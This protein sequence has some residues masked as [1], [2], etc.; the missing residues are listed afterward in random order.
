MSDTSVVIMV[1][2]ASDRERLDL[3]RSELVGALSDQALAGCSVVVAANKQDVHSALGAEEVADALGLRGLRGHAWRVVETSAA[4]GQGLDE[5]LDAAA[6]PEGSLLS[7]EDSLKH[8]PEQGLLDRALPHPPRKRSLS[9]VSSRWS[10][11]LAR[12][13]QHMLSQAI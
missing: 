9:R 12:D 3:A 6:T 10:F 11:R 2:D 1:V 8:E 13:V 5:M 7:G 4:S